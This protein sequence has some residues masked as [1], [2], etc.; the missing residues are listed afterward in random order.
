[1]LGGSR[2]SSKHLILE[3]QTK[4]DPIVLK[5]GCRHIEIGISGQDE[6]GLRTSTSN[7]GH[8]QLFKVSGGPCHT[9]YSRTKD[10]S[11]DSQSEPKYNFLTL[12]EQTDL[13][14]F[15]YL[16]Y[17]DILVYERLGKEV[18]GLQYALEGHLTRLFSDIFKRIKADYVNAKIYLLADL[19]ANDCYLKAI[20]YI[21]LKVMHARS[22]ILIPTPL[23]CCIGAGTMDGLIVDF[24]WNHVTVVPV[25]DGRVL[26][27]YA[28]Y[29][30]RAGKM[31]HYHLLAELGSKV[32]TSGRSF[33]ELEELIEN[34]ERG[35][36]EKEGDDQE[37]SDKR[38]I[39][40]TSGDAQEYDVKT[41]TVKEQ[42]EEEKEY[43][44]KRE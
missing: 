26:S 30:D 18:G 44:K 14:W 11:S 28:L 41:N 16:F 43:K 35:E 3:D 33:D 1:M 25:Y 8:K 9:I 39:Q 37:K 7:Y 10:D 20:L 36:G 27:N 15:R 31:V 32:K 21:L 23:M 5:I 4:D 22:V 2:R 42:K 29:T 13:E 40:K 34:T 24:G 19:F 38:D 6:P 17:P 12:E